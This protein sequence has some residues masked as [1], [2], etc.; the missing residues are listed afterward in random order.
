MKKIIVASLVALTM[1]ASAIAGNPK[2]E[3]RGAWMHTIHQKQYKEKS[4]EELKEYLK[5]QLDKLQAA[6]VNA[7]LFQVR[8]SA[9]ALYPSQLEPWSR[10]LTDDGKAPEP[11]WDPLEF[12]VEETH[13]RGMELHAWLNPYRVTTSKNDVL[14]KN[15]LFYK[16]PWRFVDYADGKKYFDPGIPENRDFITAVVMDIVNRYD[17]DGIHM[18]DYFYPYPV[19]DAEF[20]DDDSYAKYGEG[21]D[22]G[23][24]RR[25]NVDF[26]IRDIHNAIAGSDRP[27][28]R[29]GVS[30]FG[31]WR[32]KASDPRGSD[33]NGLQNYDALFAD[34]LLWDKEGWVDYTL[35]QLYWELEHPRASTLVLADWWN[36]IGLQHHLYIGQDTHNIMKH[37]DLAPSTNPT[38]L[39]HKITLSRQLPNVHGN[40]WWPGYAITDNFGGIADSLANNQQSTIALVPE[41]PWMKSEKPAA[42]KLAPV[43]PGDDRLKWA[44]P[45][46]KGDI[47]D[48]TSFVVYRFDV[49]ADNMNFDDP[50]NI[51]MVTRENS[52]PLVIPGRYAVTGL[53]RANKEG[54]L[55]RVAIFDPESIQKLIPDNN[56]N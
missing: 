54:K 25:R 55:E 42:I 5:D 22:R 19:Q 6:G 24:W 30:P 26:L 18:D 40:C 2:R 49:D 17:V 13:R 44:R 51:Y 12:M 4:T 45:E 28:V 50:A 41:Y 14:P 35:P 10:F 29:F 27:W 34:V 15:H 32:N 7:V 48:V 21:M 1:A 53:N 47:N 8:P 11:F 38:Q 31:I 43:R 56:Q 16:E 33:T 23:D 3:F 9:D 20:P 36:N 52:I 37:P 46:I 39:D